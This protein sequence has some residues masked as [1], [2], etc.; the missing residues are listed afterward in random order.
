MNTQLD[1][2][3]VAAPRSDVAAR[4]DWP[5][6]LTAAA[7][8][9]VVARVIALLLQLLVHSTG[10]HPQAQLP[11]G[12]LI[13]GPMNEL[14]SWDASWYLGLAEHGY[15]AYG[16]TG[17]RFSPLLPLLTRG[18]SAIG[19]PAAGAILMICWAAAFFFG[20]M[21][22]RL[23][24]DVT[25]D[26]ATASRAAWLSQLA[27]GAFALVMGYSEALAGLCAATFLVAVLRPADGSR[28]TRLWLVGGFVA[29]IAGGMDRPIGLL[30][31]LPGLIEL[32]RH[33]RAPA[34]QLAARFAVA[35]SPLLGTGF[36][37]AWCQRVYG[38]FMLPY[39]V[40]STPGLHGGLAT[41]PLQSIWHML[42]ASSTTGTE[43]LTVILAVVAVGLLW[44]CARRLPASLTAWAT[45]M[46]LSGLTAVQLAGYARYASAAIPLLIAA[47][48]LAKDRRAWA[49][50]LGASTFMFTYL[51]YAAF[52][53]WYIP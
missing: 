51:C 17:V 52:T 12:T 7:P 5:S 8:A 41:D 42:N 1:T 18:V 37:L 39:S 6:A 34:G 31:A 20:V 50:T 45:V 10:Q 38:K 22:Y 27:P 26:R 14:L 46:V 43:M 47:A 25:G 36:Y 13:N 40:Q 49:W 29:G 44:V 48:M 33:R 28:A 35:I 2:G 11:D 9:W 4:F 23:A 19:I 16:V 24:L 30:L 32:I 21:V 3:T 53:G 15:A